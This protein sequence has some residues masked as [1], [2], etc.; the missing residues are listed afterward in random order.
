MAA[1]G[2]TK[3]M[4][5]RVSLTP[6][7]KAKSILL[8]ALANTPL[9]SEHCSLPAAL[10][11][12]ISSNLLSPED[13][14]AHPR[15]TMDGFAVRAADTFGASSS[16]PCYL[17]I[18][19]EVAM[20]QM[21]EGEVRQGKCFRIATG[22][23]LPK[24]SDA[25][26]MFEHTIPV[27]EKMIEVVKSVG[28]GINLIN[29]GEDIK[30]D[31]PALAKGH[32][33]RPQDLGL[34][35]GL[36]IAEVKVYRQPK[37]AILSTGDEVVP[38]SESPP[39]GKIRDING[40]TLAALCRRLGAEVTDYGIVSDSEETF[41]I[42]LQR[43]TSENNVVLFS[44]G[45]SVGMRDLGE[46]VIEKLGNPGILVHGVALK[47]GKPIIIGLT[48]DTAIFGLPGH[49]VSAM[50]CF[51]LFVNPALRLLAG[52]PHPENSRQASVNATLDRNINSAA[53][54]LDL[55]RVQ[56]EEQED[57]TLLAVPVLG[58]SGSISTLS[59]ADGYFFIDEATQGL[60]KHTHIKVYLLS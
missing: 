35:A 8:S 12:I 1:D 40:I 30:K 3:D 2:V 9:Q 43:A 49:P 41:F 55:V 25:V 56:L 34:L 46:R 54:R 31:S 50:V 11:R 16:M 53:G 10:D 51:E 37:V 44:G 5:G 29:R 13:L 47:P 18:D 22:G 14:P 38:W 27:D 17:E 42:T 20:G 48:N 24:G 57:N 36:G 4:L 15:S 39:P 19:G 33:L 6:V 58:K 28:V 21:P 59:R 45:S 32:L 60:N 23:L 26:V 52:I 7:E